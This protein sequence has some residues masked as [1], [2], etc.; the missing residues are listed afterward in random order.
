MYGEALETS[1]N[2][3]GTLEKQQEIALDSLANKMDILKATAEDLYDSLFNT[4]TI[5]GFVEAGTG[6]LQFLADFTDSVGG[7]NNILPMLLS[8]MTGLF[9]QQI[10]NGIGTIVNNLRIA[11]EQEQLMA[12]NAEQLK[13]M[14]SDTSFIQALSGGGVTGSAAAESFN[15]LEQYYNKMQQYQHLMTQEEKEQYNLILNSIASAGDLN[16][17]IAQQ[18]DN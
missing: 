6:V 12:Q 3:A 8:T 13:T 2:A 4:D 1:M 17:Q 11:N 5:S 16:V 18:S 10:A 9:S 14:F 15:Q 7:L